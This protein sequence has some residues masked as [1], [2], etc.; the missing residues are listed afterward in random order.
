MNMN[1]DVP[2]EDRVHGA[3]SGSS[4][5][6]RLSS[7]RG[8]SAASG[9]GQFTPPPPTVAANDKKYT[10]EE[11]KLQLDPE[12]WVAASGAPKKGHLY[13]FGHSMD[14]GRVLSGASSSG[15]QETSAFT[16]PGA[17]GTSPSEMMGFIRDEI[18]GSDSRLVHTVHTQVSDDVQAQLS[19]DISQAISQALSQVSIPLQ[20]VPSTSARAPHA[21]KLNLL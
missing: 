16:T 11:E 13:G 14:M 20:A 12:V 10:G 15:S 19:Q 8:S 7:G 4:S 21:S 9:S 3:R 5:G 6:R 17:P 18:S 2:Y 1:F